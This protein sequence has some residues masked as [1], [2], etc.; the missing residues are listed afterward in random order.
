VAGTD[1]R[2]RVALVTGAS[3]AIGSA[4]V[5]RLAADGF[6]AVSAWRSTPPA[7]DGPAVQ[8]DVTDADAVRAAVE[9]VEHDHGPIHTV[10][11]NAGWAHMDIV[12][13]TDPERFRAVIDANLTGSFLV[14]QAALGPM[15][16]R[17]A[18]R[19]VFVGS[20]AGFWG[21]PG[22]ASYAASKAGLL[23]LA[24][25]LAREVG[26]RS[27]TVNVVA[28]GLLDNAVDRIDAERPARSVTT[29]WVAATPLRRAGTPDDVAAAVS[30]LA[31]EG[32]GFVTGTVI[33]V[34]GGFSMGIG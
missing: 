23:G 4:C 31:S 5:Q 27:I 2:P 7:G 28:P 14:A 6:T 34:D 26:S 9:Q 3:G 22:V 32:A 8:C 21:V 10:V 12:T 24:R 20:V 17:R 15:L 19:I 1:E 11:A 25:S 29:D 33:P 13:R 30:F 18:G 16:R